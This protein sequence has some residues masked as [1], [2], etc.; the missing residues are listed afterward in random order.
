VK[1]KLGM[2]NL[3]TAA[4]AVLLPRMSYYLDRGHLKEAGTLIDKTLTAVCMVSF[5]SVCCLIMLAPECI[6]LL[7]GSEF[8][9]AVLPM[10]IIMPAV[11]FIG[12][13]NIAGMQK[14]I[15]MGHESSVTR[16]AW[17]GAAVDIVLNT[18]LIPEFASAGA[19]AAT[20]ITELT[21]MIFLLRAVKKA[22]GKSLFSGTSIAGIAIAAVLAMPACIPA[23]GISPALP[24]RI[25][26]SGCCYLAVYI[27]LILLIW[28]RNGLLR[29]N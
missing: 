21:V 15:P 8:E 5:P 19:A 20:L 3:V 25:F 16:A 27:I 29:G 6:A 7:A 10:L 9:G 4:S 17:T 23:S 22:D 26:A 14:L 13:S 24:L 28:R 11:I 12:I 2:V 1:I 18:L